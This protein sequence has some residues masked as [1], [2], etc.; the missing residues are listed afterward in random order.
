MILED[1]PMWLCSKK[2][3][4]T[5]IGV[6][7]SLLE[8]CTLKIRNIPPCQEGSSC[9]DWKW[10]HL[11]MLAHLLK[12]WNPSSAT[13]ARLVLAVALLVLSACVSLLPAWLLQWF[14]GQKLEQSSGLSD[15]FTERKVCEGEKIQLSCEE[16]Q[17][18]FIFFWKIN[19]LFMSVILL[20][21]RA[22]LLEAFRSL[23]NHRTVG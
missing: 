18:F 23:Q 12:Q 5:E 15:V 7:T 22:G 13:I 19:K 11:E 4:E 2:R 6:P 1:N 20:I 21:C 3:G 16:N 14:T 9:S 10:R 8:R 17:G